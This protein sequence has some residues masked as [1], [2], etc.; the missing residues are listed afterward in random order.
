MKEK[1]DRPDMPVDKKKKKSPPVAPDAKKTHKKPSVD[2]VGTTI[3]LGRSI[4]AGGSYVV[5]V[6]HK[7][8]DDFNAFTQGAQ[9]SKQRT[10]RGRFA[11]RTKLPKNLT[12]IIFL[13]SIFLIMSVALMVLNNASVT[14]DRQTISL[15]GLPKEL[16][17]FNL[18]L[19][20]DLHARSFGVGQTS[21]LRTIN[22]LSYN[23]IVFAGDMVGK[24]GNPEPFFELLDGITANRPMYFISG[25]SDPDPLLSETRGTVGTLNQLVLSDWALGAIERGATYL[26]AT[27]GIKAGSATLWLT[28]SSRLSEN[29]QESLKL[30]NE[31]V[32]VEA[33][34]TIEG[35]QTDREILPFTSFRRNQLKKTDE[36]MRQMKQEDVHI[37][38]S[39]FPPTKEY[40][41]VTQQLY[42]GDEF[43]YEYLPTV[44][45]VLAG[46]YCGGGWKL[47][48]VG[49]LYVPNT[50]L[51]RRGWFPAQEDVQGI[52]RLGSTQLYTSPGLSVTD[53]LWLP[54]FRLFNSPTITILTFTSAVTGD[55]LGG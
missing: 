1:N 29:I 45:L 34:G 31:Q 22:G 3:R 32:T 17:G 28:P 10:R 14:V 8:Y 43:Q 53:A 24:S 27:S 46:H 20:S 4:R 38:V 16:E 25:D 13:L 37:A 41:E 49:A 55:L 26:T 12:Y 35:L 40:I 21:L 39:H 5:K 7:A 19:I 6:S 50:F 15:V 47:P 36:A 11:P 42:T 30:F 2:P 44:D 9:P 18:L 51:D 52:K 23:A 48:F 54:N 33:E